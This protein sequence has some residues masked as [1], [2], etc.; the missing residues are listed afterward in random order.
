MPL[1]FPKLCLTPHSP[2]PAPTHL[3]IF[4]APSRSSP[5]RSF[6][7]AQI[8]LPRLLPDARTSFLL[9][10]RA[11]CL[12]LCCAPAEVLLMALCSSSRARPQPGRAPWC[13]VPQ[14]AFLQLVV[15]PPF[16]L[17]RPRHGASSSARPSL[18]LTVPWCLPLFPISCSSMALS[19]T[20]RWFET[21]SPTT[22][23]HGAQLGLPLLLVPP[24]RS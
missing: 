7:P 13:R 2:A 4:S 17:L 20:S 6:L 8:F 23:F 24:T 5:S 1:S 12:L 14:L 19:S 9:L 16:P 3:A 15:G 18:S 10:C 22:I 21:P 11:C